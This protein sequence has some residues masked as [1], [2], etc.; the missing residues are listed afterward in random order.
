VL[1]TG[2]IQTSTGTMRGKLADEWSTVA[3]DIGTNVGAM[4]VSMHILSTNTGTE[5]ATQLVSWQGFDA[6]V[7]T[8]MKDSG[9]AIS[10]L[11]PTM[12]EQ[13][14]AWSKRLAS[15]A[16][17]YTNFQTNLTTIMAA[18]VAAH[19]KNPQDIIAAL[20]KAGPDVTAHMAADL[21]Q[22][23]VDAVTST[24]SNLATVAAG[25]PPGMVEGV[26]R[27]AF[28]WTDRMHQLGLDGSAAVQAGVGDISTIGANLAHDMA[29]GITDH[30]WEVANAAAALGDAVPVTVRHMLGMQS[31][32]TVLIDIGK[33]IDASLIQ[34]LQADKNNI[35][36]Q[37][38][39]VTLAIATS[40]DPTKTKYL[41]SVKGGLEAKLAEIMAAA[42]VAI[43]ANPLTIPAPTVGSSGNPGGGPAQTGGIT[44]TPTPGWQLA[45]TPNDHGASILS[46]G[47]FDA[48]AAALGPLYGTMD[49]GGLAFVPGAEF[50]KL[51]SS[52]INGIISMLNAKFSN[53]ATFRAATGV[54]DNSQQGLFD[55][56]M[57]DLRVHGLS[58]DQGGWL[59]PGMT[60]AI[61]NTGVPER[62]GGG[63]NV[64]ITI[65]L[66]G[67]ATDADG[68]R[69]AV[70]I[71]RELA[72]AAA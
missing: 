10:G 2:D 35:E 17:D 32:S 62:V 68:R 42:Q 70:A 47:E 19:V 37:L 45:Y 5:T 57:G 51:Q 24:L 58:F 53:A 56:L 8:A 11:L 18:L 64:T 60:V 52:P 12:N 21:A 7:A 30:E 1:A 36:L 50:A 26:E 3:S 38:Q 29:G 65:N 6:A 9:T 33:N 44:G 67:G 39:E 43:N 31:P 63:P 71:K 28:N 55:T 66:K 59:Q 69:V 72:A 20:D 46:L 27:T 25:V 54:T 61:N 14:D 48:I 4:S 34:G 40:L 22:G 13:F 15:E 16:L 23:G 41:E 49:A